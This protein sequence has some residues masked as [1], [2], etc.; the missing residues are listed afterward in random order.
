MSRNIL[1]II[2]LISPSGFLIYVNEPIVTLSV[3]MVPREAV[4]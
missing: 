4:D 1:W 3:E 2:I